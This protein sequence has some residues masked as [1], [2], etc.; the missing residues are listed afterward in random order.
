[1]PLSMDAVER[2]VRLYLTESGESPFQEWFDDLG[3]IR[4]QD[5]ILA[6]IA[7]LRLGNP[8]DWKTVGGGVYEM[9]IGYGPGYRLYFGQ[10]RQPACD[11]A[12]RWRQKHAAKGHQTRKGVLV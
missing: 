8:G 10:E 7:R 4:A 2:I 6:R 5:H 11:P 12:D 9:R 1:M 3:D